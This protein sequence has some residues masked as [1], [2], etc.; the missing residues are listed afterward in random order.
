MYGK[1]KN[2]KKNNKMGPFTEEETMAI[3]FNNAAIKRIMQTRTVGKPGAA[4]TTFVTKKPK[5]KA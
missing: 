1:D 5:V 4:G 3:P 2:K